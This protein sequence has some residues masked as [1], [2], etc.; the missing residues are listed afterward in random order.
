MDRQKF[1]F[2]FGEI[3]FGSVNG[4]AYGQIFCMAYDPAAK[5]FTPW[6]PK[7]NQ[8]RRRKQE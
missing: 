7:L 8:R 2:L 6:H 4:T 3:G 5:G 1:L